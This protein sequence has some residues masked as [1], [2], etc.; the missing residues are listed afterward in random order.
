MRECY[1]K[2]CGAKF[3]MNDDAKMLLPLDDEL[4]AVHDDMLGI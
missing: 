3:G 2:R 1:C 4:K